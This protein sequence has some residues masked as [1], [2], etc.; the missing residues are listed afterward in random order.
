MSTRKPERHSRTDPG[1]HRGRHKFGLY[2]YN[3]DGGVSEPLFSAMMKDVREIEPRMKHDGLTAFAEQGFLLVDA[4][5][6]R[7]TTTTSPA[8]RG[9][10]SFSPI[11]P[12]S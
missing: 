3:P 10:R 7:L 9:T 8:S 5:S 1:N 6:T 4:T 11:Y 12:F 2:F